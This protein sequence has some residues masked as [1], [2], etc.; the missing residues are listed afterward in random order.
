VD[1]TNGSKK[2]RAKWIQLARNIGMKVIA[3]EFW[4]TLATLTARQKSRDDKE[5]PYSSLKQQYFAQTCAWHG[6]EVDEVIVVPGT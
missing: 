1:N 6:S 5:V 4:H 2:S 3:V